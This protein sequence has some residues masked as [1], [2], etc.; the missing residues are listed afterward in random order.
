MKKIREYAGIVLMVT[1]FIVMVGV[2]GRADYATATRTA[3]SDFKLLLGLGVGVM[4]MTIGGLLKG[5]L[6]W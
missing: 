3:F 5:W 2:T 4:L 6:H 1:G